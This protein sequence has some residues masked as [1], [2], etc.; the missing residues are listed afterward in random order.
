L[1]SDADVLGHR[2]A[3]E[4]Q[5]VDH[6]AIHQIDLDETTAAE[7]AGEDRVLTVD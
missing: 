1:R 6:L 2:L 5:R 3:L 4:L 7:V